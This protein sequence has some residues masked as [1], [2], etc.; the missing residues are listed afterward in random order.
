DNDWLP[1]PSGISRESHNS[2][3]RDLLSQFDKINPTDD[4]SIVSIDQCSIKSVSI[5]QSS[6][7]IQETR[8]GRDTNTVAP[9]G[10]STRPRSAVDL[11]RKS[12]MYLK[13]KFYDDESI[14]HSWAMKRRKSQKPREA[15]PLSKVAI[16][17]TI[18]LK[19]KD[20]QQ[21]DNASMYHHHHQQQPNTSHLIQP[22]VITQYPPKP[23]VYSPV[24]PLVDNNP[25]EKTLHRL[26]MPLM[27]LTAIQQD[28]A[29]KKRRSDSDLLDQAIAKPSV[30]HSLS[31]TWNKLLH[32]CSLRHKKNN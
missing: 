13:S 10:K 8:Y 32:S 4:D 27:K 18:N 23:L 7:S 14:F 24:E 2:F 17:T 3:T 12:S 22:P 30:I 1:L 19:K 28:K 29:V 11:L 31:K 21:H 26:S 5:H 25:Q 20:R 16:N 9:N 15:L 6:I